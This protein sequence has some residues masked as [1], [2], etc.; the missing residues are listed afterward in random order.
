VDL[1]SAGGYLEEPRLTTPDLTYIIAI[2]HYVED[3]EETR[4]TL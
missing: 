3:D 1:V 4:P 2:N